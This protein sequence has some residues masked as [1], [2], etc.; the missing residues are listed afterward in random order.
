MSKPR[1][2]SRKVTGFNHHCHWRKATI[3]LAQCVVATLQADG[4]IGM[5]SGL[6]MKTV[7]GERI[8]E[9]WDKD[10]IEAL[11]FIGIEVGEKKPARQARST[12]PASRKFA[13]K[14]T[15]ARDTPQDAKDAA[16]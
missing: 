4:K 9:R 16:R 11:A 1:V 13:V 2:R 12:K 5:G 7:G 3:L 6:V 10:F 15:S 8:V 14:S